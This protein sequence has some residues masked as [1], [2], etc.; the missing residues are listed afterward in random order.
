[1]VLFDSQY[2]L[3]GVTDKVLAE[4]LSMRI[5]VEAELDQD[6]EPHIVGT[7]NHMVMSAVC[8]EDGADEPV[9]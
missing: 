5:D 1:M 8:V 6:G 4:L 9:G 7:D 3:P 2:P